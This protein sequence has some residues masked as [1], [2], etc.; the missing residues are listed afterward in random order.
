MI[1]RFRLDDP[2]DG[3]VRGHAGADEDGEHDRE[4]RVALGTCRAE[5]EGDAQRD[6]CQRVP[7]VVD[8]IREQGNASRKG[9]DRRLRGGR[10]AENEEREKDRAQ[11]GARSHDRAVDQPV[12]VA[13]I[14]M[15]M[16]VI[17]LHR[18]QP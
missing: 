2:D 15:R 1:G 5:S 13:V 16:R 6:G 18:D 4:P 12:T 17:V 8:E 9:V 3:F 11:A 10:E 14:A 7:D